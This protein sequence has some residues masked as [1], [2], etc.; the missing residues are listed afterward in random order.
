M[1]L[2]HSGLCLGS[3][4]PILRGN[5]MMN[6]LIFVQGFEEKQC[7]K[8]L[9]VLTSNFT[10]AESFLSE[11]KEGNSGG[12]DRKQYSPRLPKPAAIHGGG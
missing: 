12:N 8:S 4:F 5:E 11:M 2:K 7:L 3:A 9:H 1:E 6:E 10:T